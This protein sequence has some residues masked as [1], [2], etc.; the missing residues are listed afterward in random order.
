MLSWL[1]NLTFSPSRLLLRGIPHGKGNFLLMEGNNIYELAV[2][3]SPDLSE[4]DVQKVIDKVK[5]SINPK[6]GVVQKEYTWGKKR[7]AYPIGKAEL[8]RKSVV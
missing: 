8:D 1:Y 6:G 5:A 7:L 2:L 3:L 4:F